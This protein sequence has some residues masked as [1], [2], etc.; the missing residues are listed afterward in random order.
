MA[1]DE[2][3][4]MVYKS[5]KT[6]VGDGFRLIDVSNDGKDVAIVGVDKVRRPIEFRRRPVII[7]P[8]VEPPEAGAVV[9]RNI[10]DLNDAIKAGS[11]FIRCAAGVYMGRISAVGTPTRVT[12]S[13]QGIRDVVFRGVE[14]VRSE[15]LDF[16][17]I[18]FEPG[19]GVA[20]SSTSSLEVNQ[21][22][23]IWFHDCLFVGAKDAAG[24]GQ[25]RCARAFQST[26]VGFRRCGFEG[27][28]KGLLAHECAGIVADD[29]TFRGMAS[30]GIN[31]VAVEGCQILD[32]DISNFRLNPNAVP[33][34]HGDAIQVFSAADDTE[35]T[36][37]LV[38]S[39]CKIDIGTGSWT[40]SIFTR[41]EGYEAKLR[42]GASPEVL[43]AARYRDWVIENNTINQAH[44]HGITVS[45]CDGLTVRGNK[46]T[47]A[48]M[49]M[50]DPY[51]AAYVAKNGPGAKIYTP[52][53]Y[54]YPDPDAPASPLD[55]TGISQ[56][57]NTINGV[58]FTQPVKK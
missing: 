23:R 48:V 44:L 26:E 49:N 51:N 4:D 1:E 33:E 14:I 22:K 8:P 2:I 18:V 29:C 36:T 5:N 52:G 21:S 58:V 47:T 16:F 35:P 13:T 10:G 20:A 31:I 6:R 3:Y 38:I 43:K 39:G 53:I 27:G 19:A 46:L 41:N 45:A 54:I 9:V 12:V 11:K 28:L 30:D 7:K 17:G 57:A 50:A 37:G 55:N 42:A 32:C 34:V 25:G 15:M 24:Y 56:S 40:Q